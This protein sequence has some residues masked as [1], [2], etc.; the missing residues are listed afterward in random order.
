MSAQP[1]YT[2]FAA[3]EYPFQ[4]LLVEDVL[5]GGA[6]DFLHPAAFLGS[7]NVLVSVRF[8]GFAFRQL[9]SSFSTVQPLELCFSAG[10]DVAFSSKGR[11]RDS[12]GFAVA[13]LGVRAKA[14]TM[15][16]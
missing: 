5:D 3:D 16:G 7:A 6:V 2:A 10:R 15:D 1:T 13:L 11:L 4:R 9:D 14:S 12:C 8:K